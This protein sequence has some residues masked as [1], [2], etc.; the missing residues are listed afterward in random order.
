MQNSISIYIIWSN[1]VMYFEN[2]NISGKIE[3]TMYLEK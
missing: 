1:F 3:F 2:K